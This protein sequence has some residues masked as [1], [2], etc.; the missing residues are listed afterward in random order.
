MRSKWSERFAR[1]CRSFGLGRGVVGL[2]LLLPILGG[3]LLAIARVDLATFRALTREDGPIEWLQ[4]VAFLG[5]AAFA[6]LTAVRLLRRGER[7]PA[8]LFFGLAVAC[9]FI[10]GEEIA[11]GERLLDLEVPE[12]IEDINDQEELTIHNIGVLLYVFNLGM[13]AVALYGVT[14]PYLAERFAHRLPR[15]W[16]FY[17]VPPMALMTAFAVPVAFRLVRFSVVRH[18]GFTVTKWGEWSELCLAAGML[19]FARLASVR[20]RAGHDPT[21]V[22]PEARA[23]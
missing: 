8:L 20:A 13:L 1:D 17:L 6:V 4:V 16:R 18:S 2:L 11:W 7:L 3:V 14:S 22:P 15:W 10:A 19:V 21:P 23:G 12:A 9:V 5:T